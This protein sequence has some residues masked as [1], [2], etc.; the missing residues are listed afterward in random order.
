MLKKIHENGQYLNE[1]DKCYKDGIMDIEKFKIDLQRQQWQAKFDLSQHEFELKKELTQTKIMQAEKEV[2][3]TNVNECDE[4]Q[5]I[6]VRAQKESLARI[7]PELP[8]S[9]NDVPPHSE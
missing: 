8:Q 6:W 5:K 9:S 3:F 1:Q 7:S 2:M 4:N